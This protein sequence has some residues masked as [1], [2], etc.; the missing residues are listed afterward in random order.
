MILAAKLQEC[1]VRI[2]GLPVLGRTS[3]FILVFMIL[4]ILRHSFLSILKGKKRKRAAYEF[5]FHRFLLQS[6][7]IDISLYNLYHK[8]EL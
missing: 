8:L 1:L 3:L 6:S 4:W 5:T 2:Q 7:I